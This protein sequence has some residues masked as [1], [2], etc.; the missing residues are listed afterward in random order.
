[1]LNRFVHELEKSISKEKI[2]WTG[3][4]GGLLPWLATT[5]IPFFRSLYAIPCQSK[6]CKLYDQNARMQGW[7]SNC[8]HSR[9]VVSRPSLKIWAALHVELPPGTDPATFAKWWAWSTR[10]TKRT[11]KDCSRWTDK[12][13]WELLE[14]PLSSFETAQALF[15]LPRWYRVSVAACHSG[16]SHIHY[17]SAKHVPGRP[18]TYKAHQLHTSWICL[19]SIVYS[20]RERVWQ[21]QICPISWC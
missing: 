4:L 10:S 12:S 1:M 15:G 6:H 9:S 5:I 8:L 16:H 7:L 17:H 3:Y 19:E 2:G 20:W 21:H 14:I 11:L 18:C 13:N